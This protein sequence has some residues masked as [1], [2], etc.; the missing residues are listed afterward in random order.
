MGTIY[1]RTTGNDTTGD[2][3]LGNPYALPSKAASVSIANDVIDVGAGTFVQGT[4]QVILPD[5]VDMQGAGATTIITSTFVGITVASCYPPCVALGNNSQVSNL[6]INAIAAARQSCIGIWFVSPHYNGNDSVTTRGAV[7]LPSGW[8]LSGL[9]L[10]ATANQSAVCAAINWFADEEEDE[11]SLLLSDTPPRAVGTLT[12]CTGT[13]K[14][15][16]LYTFAAYY[17]HLAYNEFGSGAS[18]VNGAQIAAQF[19]MKTSVC[20]F[21]TANSTVNSATFSTKAIRC[22]AG[23]IELHDTNVAASDTISPSP[24]GAGGTACLST[25]FFGRIVMLG[26]SLTWARTTGTPYYAD[27]NTGHTP[28]GARIILVQ[29][30][31]ATSKTGGITGDTA[32]VVDVSV[33]PDENTVKTTVTAYGPTG[34]DYAGSVDVPALEAAANAAGAAAQLV[35]DQAAVDA[36]KAD[37]KTTRTILT[38]TGTYDVAAANAAAAATQLATDVAAVSAKAAYIYPNASILGLNN[39]TLRASNIG[40][41]AGTDNLTAGRLGVG[42][43]VDNIVGS[44]IVTTPNNANQCTGTLTLV[45]EYGAAEGADITVTFQAMP[46]KVGSGYGFDNTQTT[47]TTNASGVITRLF[48]AGAVWYRWKRGTGPWVNFQTALIPNTS[49]DIPNNVGTP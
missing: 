7:S 42:F 12:N 37:I 19:T 15:H 18:G 2:G 17:D 27:V 30:T 36:G 26:G 47:S 29:P 1:V 20:S 45:N 8:V 10:D 21:T 5:D 41:L 23:Q 4:T 46:P 22:M 28:T 9:T 16:C 6:R 24:T 35:T 38:I 13:A 31:F 3:T 25:G 14:T 40:T 33:F 43:T 39:G 34:A 44:G 32:N 49:F 11:I 48:P